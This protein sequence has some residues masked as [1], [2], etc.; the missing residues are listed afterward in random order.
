MGVEL[1][2]E[3]GSERRAEEELGSRRR[4]DSDRSIERRPGGAWV[5]RA[6]KLIYLD[7]LNIF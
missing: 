6:I 3:E 7:Y 5:V 4:R 2:I 1:R